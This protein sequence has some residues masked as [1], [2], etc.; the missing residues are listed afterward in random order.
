MVIF[1]IGEL[2]D[3]VVSYIV[4]NIDSA[5]EQ[6]EDGSTIFN[7]TELHEQ[8]LSKIELWLPTNQPGDS[9]LVL[10]WEK[11]GRGVFYGFQRWQL[12]EILRKFV[13]ELDPSDTDLILKELREIKNAQT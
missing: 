1:S 12:L 7:R 9:Y 8:S 5:V 3:R 2:G 6:V 11:D 4:R 13:G 10:R